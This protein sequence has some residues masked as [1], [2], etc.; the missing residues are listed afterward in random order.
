MD[1]YKIYVDLLSKYQVSNSVIEQSWTEL[2]A[3]YTASTRYYHNL[4]HLSEMLAVSEAIKPEINNYDAF[5]FAVFFHDIIYRIP[6][7]TNEPDSA[8]YAQKLMTKLNISEPVIALCC[9]HITATQFH[10]KHG[11]NDTNLILDC[12][13]T[14]LASEPV[15]YKE[16]TRQIRN[17]Y[18]IYSAV[19]YNLGRIKVLNHFLTM[20]TIYKTNWFIANFENKA[21]QNVHYELNVLNA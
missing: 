18:R 6:S 8:E 2:S 14:V 16:Y 17:E 5:C 9:Q 20:P 13:L 7:K 21:R 10:K 1:I 12:D 15:R 3:A 11:N 4:L 19:E